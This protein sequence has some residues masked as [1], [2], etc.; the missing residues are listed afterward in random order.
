MMNNKTKI[1]KPAANLNDVFNNFSPEP[2]TGH[3]EFKAF[4][5]GAVN[6]VRGEDKVKRISLGLERAFEGSRFK[7]LVAGHPGVGKS[8]ELTKLA[9][10]IEDKFKVIRFSVTNELDPVSFRPFDVLLLIMIETAERTAQ[11]LKDEKS[12]ETLSESLLTDIWDWFSSETVTQE[13]ATRIAVGM[14]AGAGADGSSIWAKTLGLFAVVKGEMKYSSD[15]NKKIVEYRLSRI[16]YLLE[17]ANRLLDECNALLYK[18]IKKE[19][20]II[21]EDFDKPGIPIAQIEGFFITYSNIL[22]NLSAHIIA[23]I[24]ITLAYSDKAALLPVIPFCIPDIPVFDKEH[25]IHKAGRKAVKTVLEARMDATLFDDGQIARLITASGGNLRDLFAMVSHATENA[26]MR[27]A[28]TISE[29]DATR[30]INYMR[31]EYRRRLGESPYDKTEI[32]LDNKVKR[33]IQVYKGESRANITNDVMHSLLRARA[34]QE[35]NGEGWYGVH[36]LVVDLLAELGKL[37]S[38]DSGS[39]AGGTK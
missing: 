16:S 3:E 31:L 28:E 11:I 23:T 36:P 6:D 22:K 21:G 5:R 26:I 38:A 32:S 34:V 2:L 37:D 15:R 20:L 4:Y 17:L 14:E 25:E 9:F 39:V 8:T 30:S 18:V 1:W 7:C 24:P 29:E 10:G 13:E 35:F 27:K 12:P 33:L 19:W